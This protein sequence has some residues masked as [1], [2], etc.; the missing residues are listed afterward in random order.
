M[1]ICVIFISHI[2]L[3]EEDAKTV[4]TNEIVDKEQINTQSNGDTGEFYTKIMLY[5]D[6]YIKVMLYNDDF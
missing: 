3:A 6:C 4:V 2:F 5:N 1:D